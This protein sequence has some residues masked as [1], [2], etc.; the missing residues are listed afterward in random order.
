[1]RVVHGARVILESSEEDDLV[2]ALGRED[3]EA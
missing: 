2:V 3:I 1:M